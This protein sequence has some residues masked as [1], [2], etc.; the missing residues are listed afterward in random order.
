VWDYP[1]LFELWCAR[2]A[3]HPVVEVTDEI[4][5]AVAAEARARAEQSAQPGG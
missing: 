5:A 3:P 2:S 4:R 1:W